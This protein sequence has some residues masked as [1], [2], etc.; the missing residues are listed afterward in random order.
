MT[1]SARGEKRSTP[2]TPVQLTAHC[3]L[4]HRFVREA[5]GDLSEGGFFLRTHEPVREGAPVRVAVALP[6]SDG[7]RICTLVGRVA[8]VHKDGRGLPAGVGVA[9][10]RQEM[11]ALDHAALHR[12]LARAAPAGASVKIA[13]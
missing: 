2:R 4:G 11:G 6:L 10:D 12:F 7:S 8:R 9:F 3:Q 5:V 13:V 1:S